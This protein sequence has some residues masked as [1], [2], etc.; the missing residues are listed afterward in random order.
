MTDILRQVMPSYLYLS[1]LILTKRDN[2][3]NVWVIIIFTKNT[4]FS[5]D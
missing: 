5:L 3:K 4:V 1:T 2:I